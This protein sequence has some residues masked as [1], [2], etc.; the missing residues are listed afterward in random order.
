MFYPGFCSSIVVVYG[1]F[2]GPDQSFL[3]LSKTCSCN[4]WTLSSFFWAAFPMSRID[5]RRT[6]GS[7]DDRQHRRERHRIDVCGSTS[8]RP[9]NRRAGAVASVWRTPHRFNAFQT[10]TC[11]LSYAA[12][13]PPCSMMARTSISHGMSPR[14]YQSSKRVLRD[15]STSNRWNYQPA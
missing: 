11:T 10:E 9:A 3:F 14:S 15:L 6:W 13:W 8:L 1:R 2:R 7:A 4:S 12:S 5:I